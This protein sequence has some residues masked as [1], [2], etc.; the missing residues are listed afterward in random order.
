MMPSE[1]TRAAEDKKGAAPE[2]FVSSVPSIS[3]PKGGGAI[4]GI[5]EKFAANP[6][7]GT[8]SLSIPVF[9]SPARAN[10]H[11]QL[12]L[13][14]D[15]G[16]GNSPFG[17]G[18]H[19]SVPVINRKTE[20][21]L[22]R[23]AD[24]EDSDTFILA[25]VEDLVP[26]LRRNGPDWVEE[27][28][29]RGEFRIRRYR[30]RIEGL[31]S[32][33]ER[34]TNN[35]TGETYWRTISRDNVTSIFGDTLE[36]RIF[37][38]ADE[39]RV[40]AW[41]LHESFDDRGNI[42]KYEYKPETDENI[43]MLAPEE[44][45]R[46]GA[47]QHFSHRYLKRILYGNDLP[48]Q[49][50][51]W[52]FQVVFD[53][54][55]HATLQPEA[56]ESAPWPARA[57]AF[58]T[59][60][61][62]FE[63]R[64]YRLCRRILMLH[65][66]AELGPTPCLVRSTDLVYAENPVASLLTAI[67]QTGYLRD[68]AS[69]QYQQKSFPPLELTYAEAVA[70]EAIHFI[71][72]ESLENLPIGVDNASYQWIDLES[73]GLS[74]ILAEQAQ[75][76]FYKRNLGQGR[77]A[78]S[79]LLATKP[80]LADL[81]SGRQQ[82]MDLAGD[83]HK[84]LVQFDGPV[85]GYYE[86]TDEDG[87]E[88][89][90]P[91]TF[92]P[93]LR[94]NDP[95]LRF[96]DLDGDGHTD[97]LITEDEVFI[98]YR[99]RDR[100]GFGPGQTV[101]K[102]YDEEKGPVV[103]FADATQS[104]YLADMSG[105]G[106]SDLVRIRNGAV[107]YWPNLGYGRFGPKVTMS[108]AP[109]FDHSEQFSEARIRLADIDGSG[110]TDIIYLGRN[111]VSFWL[112]QSG[113]SWSAPR[114]L[115]EFPEVDDLSA[116]MVVDLLGNG[117]ACLVWSSPLPGAQSRRQMR[118]LDLMSG[119]KPY[120]LRSMKNNLG[121]ETRIAYAPSTR[122]Y[123]QDRDAGTPWVTKLPFPVHV[124]E[125]V[126]TY[127]WV[128]RNRF[129]TRYV[130]H[131][132][133]YDGVERE[134]RGFGMV[135]QFDAEELVALEA[136]GALFHVPAD[137]MDEA[138][139]LPP[140]HTKTWFHTGAYLKEDEISRRYAS[141][142]Y[143]EPGLTD[144]EAEDRLLADSRLVSLPTSL[145]A[146]ELTTRERMEALRS[147]KGSILRQ[148]VF[149]Q[150]GSSKS[151]FPYT[152]SERSYE[153]NPLQPMSANDHA[154]FFVHACETIDYHYERNPRDART[155]HQ[156]TL[157]VDNVG[158][159]KRSA[160]VAYGRRVADVNLS[161]QDQSKQAHSLITYTENGLTN[162]I[163]DADAYRT[164]LL[165]ETRT[166]ELTG[167]STSGLVRLTADALLTAGA[168]A[169]PLDYEMIPGGG[170]CKRLIEHTRWLFLKDDLS[171]PLPLG[172][173]EALAMPYESYRQ[174]FTPGLIAGTLGSRVDDSLLSI[175][176]G[177]VHSEGDANWWIPSG[178]SVYAADAPNHFYLP[179][180]F[181]DAFGNSTTLTY[182]YD[183]LV[184]QTVDPLQNSVL[185][186]Y[187]YRLLK[188]RM[189]TDSN[190]NRSEVACD[191]LGMVVGTA[192]M[193][194]AKEDKGDSL[195]GFVPELDDATIIEHLENPL[196]QPE[197]I[198]GQATTRLVYD[199]WRYH[200]TRQVMPDGTEQGQPVVAYKLAR[201]RHESDLTAG[202]VTPVQHSFIYSDGFGREIQKKIQAEPGDVGG[203]HRDVRWVGSGW[204][205]FDNKGQAV[206]QFEPFFT[207]THAF[208]FNKQHGVSLTVFYDPLGRAVA[209][210]YPDH[211]Y[212]KSLFD[213]WQQTL[214]DRN[215]TITQTDPS[216]DPDVGAFFGKLDDAEYLPGWY[217]SRRNGQLGDAQ[218][219]AAAKAAAHANT[220][221]VVHL[222]A[223]ARSFLK[224]AD[225]GASGSYQTRIELDIEGNQRSIVDARGNATVYDFDMLS[226]MIHSSSMDAGE[227]WLLTN[228]GGAPAIS[229]DGPE[230]DPQ[231]HRTRRAYDELRRP[232]QLFMRQ[233]TGAELMIEHTVYGEAQGAALN[234]RGKLYQ[235]FDGAGLTTN[236]EY[237]FKGNLLRSTRRLA[238]D[239]QNTLDW[240]QPQ[241]LDSH[242][243]TSS[244]AYDAL[245]RPT[246]LTLPDA[247]IISPTYNRASLLEQVSVNLR[248]AQDAMTFVTNIDYSAKGQ[249]EL[250]EYG[251]GARTSYTYDD[252][253]FRLTHLLTTRSAGLNPSQDLSYTYDPIGNITGISDAAQQTIYFDNSVVTP[254]ASFTYDAI[255][256]LI[257]ANGREHIGQNSSPQVDEDDRPRM[258]QPHPSDGQAMRNYTEAYAYD[259]VGN[260]LSILHQSA[261]QTLWKRLYDYAPD[262]NRLLSTSLPGDADAAPFSARY[263]YDAHG[264]MVKMP[265]LAAM[266][267]DFHDQLRA[268]QRQVVSGGGPAEKVFYVYDSTGHRARKVVT[269]PGG[270]IKEE[271]I[272]LGG[273]EIFRQYDAGGATTLEREAL[274]VMDDHRRIALVETKTQ[275]AGAPPGALPSTLTRYQLDNHLGSSSLELDEHG[276]VISYEEYY[277][278]GSTS[279]QAGRS[280]AE[281]SLKRYRYTGKERD[282]ETG[283][284]YQ[285]ARYY[286]PWLGRWTSCDP[287]GMVDGP[288]PYRYGRNNPILY[289]DPNGK[290]P[291]PE[292]KLYEASR[293]LSGLRDT[294]KG[295]NFSEIVFVIL[296][297]LEKHPSIPF[298]RALWLIIQTRGEQGTALIK[299]RMFN[300]MPVLD[301]N[302]VQRDAAGRIL[303]IPIAKGQID[304]DRGI[305]YEML[306]SHEDAIKA[307]E[308]TEG[309][310]AT[311]GAAAGE[312]KSPFF[313]YKT[314]EM[315]VEHHLEVLEK[316]FSKAF[317]VLTGATGTLEQYAQTLKDLRYATDDKYVEKIKNISNTLPAEL[318]A[319]IPTEIKQNEAVIQYIKDKTAEMQATLSGLQSLLPALEALV[320]G[321]E[322]VA[323]A[324]SGEAAGPL[325]E[326]LKTTR[327]QIGN[328]K[329]QIDTLTQSIEWNR[330]SIKV[331]EE[332]NRRLEKFLKLIP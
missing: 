145:A 27:I 284:Y 47:Q 127:D 7:T 98:W 141:E 124:V 57:D 281:V 242:L 317:G 327:A 275:E 266:E 177:Y 143:R 330:K 326:Q 108:H 329:A 157:E 31:F 294:P 226:N 296:S 325:N 184:D 175:E 332:Q 136:G 110:T 126:E 243:F 87:W 303:N 228:V 176:C 240:S 211:T 107:C 132:G 16:S 273:Y 48:H 23:Y 298:E 79:R 276:A 149:A 93:N 4:K 97:I 190:G 65:S 163:D 269:R 60:R 264:N 123:L 78:P 231:T 274:H 90:H 319:W 280:A 300:Q 58:S 219:D 52:R 278:Y 155:T 116:V 99:S 220:P 88:P 233:G 63:V 263:D 312:K 203:M 304:P 15:S 289:I 173:I 80:T 283:L 262:S 307:E 154:V 208:E 10:F 246:S 129:T 293:A 305:D 20:K 239:F 306:M 315:A 309:K 151:P 159:V 82:L 68:E 322:A 314:K 150:D 40:F 142:Y 148:E 18:W 96:I 56:E 84:Y 215:D 144:K 245:E 292:E 122:F 236:E 45:N 32:R 279:Y 26:S 138:H 14:Y 113:N 73:E 71:E 111:R 130:Y 50:S 260:I 192:V 103:I 119:Q 115:Q 86:C 13:S 95:N 193:G 146:S 114:E 195:A 212:E 44:R 311:P 178:R 230:N 85:S 247:S 139:Y 9:T 313:I 213:A 38:P 64:T 66:F 295:H 94:W 165:C 185:T 299:N 270:S 36:S 41:L 43:D 156:L 286:A 118:Y 17:L 207:D 77:F 297:T 235:S 46:L 229:W 198:L 217:E 214:W 272:Y 250:I 137:N 258:S 199:L 158:N 253:T 216:A 30:P 249:R 121:S 254:S 234:L 191:I 291:T 206:K 76:W 25:G 200:R 204:T 285:G 83:G 331:V 39:S 318:K 54:G 167:L 69:G 140:V 162:W 105:D 117:M 67:T 182:R 59:Y 183:L 251:N 227:R 323:A 252:K 92:N 259:S 74:G 61:P 51:G 194:K 164:P 112:N 152:V 160:V 172:H 188:P 282:E 328:V 174:A 244:T 221:G 301:W 180:G 171:G 91:F 209:R 288:N 308:A 49:Q 29:H 62:G 186:E 147:L 153:I 224:I 1:T 268:T 3:L 101:R 55:D 223:L 238:V 232:V 255:Y 210:L 21:G 201:E 104:I 19:L 248:G 109:V 181:T 6:A 70:D 310:P 89:F 321:L 241:L 120:L 28:S 161:A 11:P 197:L 316:R 169:T 237:D 189:I 256:Q 128:S 202:E 302:K 133:Y 324:T 166:Y 277:P 290:A 168:T 125:R 42:I 196:A 106:L 12:S 22:P 179:T 102:L 287:A 218:K 261:S 271:R 33:I 37:D 225:N 5:G 265:H 2:G 134:F 24:D 100:E 257:L 81:A 267:W 222:D 135:E 35:K 72:D 187:D 8:G 53:Y 131:H 320:R 170:L 75:A 205:I 34:W